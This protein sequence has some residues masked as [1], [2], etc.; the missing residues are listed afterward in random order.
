M[1]PKTT[2]TAAAIAISNPLPPSL[3]ACPVN[4]GIVGPPGGGA[5]APVPVAKPVPVPVAVLFVVVVSMT[6]LGSTTL[7][8]DRGYGAPVAEVLNVGVGNGAV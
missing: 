1:T 6:I 8:E 4:A 5:S 7:V 3:L 2:A